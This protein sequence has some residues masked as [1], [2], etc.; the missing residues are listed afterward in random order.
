MNLVQMSFSGAIMIL[1]ISIIRAFALNRLP[2]RTFPVLWSFV[3]MR[4]LLPFSIPSALSAYTLLEQQT[5]AMESLQ[6]TPAVNILP[7]STAAQPVTAPADT[8][9]TSAHSPETFSIWTLLWAIGAL[10]CFLYFAISYIKCYK[11]FRISLPVENDFII[12]WLSTHKLRRTVSIRQA[13][14]ISTPLTYGILHPVILLPKN[15][16]LENTESLQYVLKHEYIHIKYW[17]TFTKFVTI[18]ALCIH[19]FNPLV[20]LM[21]VLL[22]RDIELSCDESVIRLLGENRKAAY[23]RTLINMEEE[24]SGLT[25]LYYGFSKNV[26]EERI[27]AIMK[28]KKIS[29]SAI[30]V[31][32]LLILGIVA[33]FATS[34]AYANTS[35]HS[36]VLNKEISPA[37]S[38]KGKLLPYKGMTYQQFQK[39]TKTNAELYHANFY[40]AI[41]PGTNAN[42]I[43]A[44][45]A[46]DETLAMN[47]LAKSDQ[48]IRIEGTL[49]ELLAEYTEEMTIDGFVSGLCWDNGVSPEYHIKEGA[50]T[51]YYTANRYVEI[52]F[53]SDGDMQKDILLQISLDHS[54]KI[55][56]NSYA[57]LI[58]N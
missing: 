36:A 25:P 17:D 18:L 14:C 48:I 3:L 29:P 52:S 26:M 8:I 58:F 53:D 43:F 35:A 57:W 21:Y 24:K 46:F 33:V 19:W 23:A 30:M 6:N 41:I 9:L 13:S 4:L 10:I 5:K 7:L 47:T 40:A 44:A 31:A 1:V 15:I 51:A 34:S 16:N 54:E 32:V 55:S 27:K 38:I 37:I 20:W 49:K 11:E 45:S 2:K 28:T 39:Q 22:N 56:P 50:G 42:V 12:C